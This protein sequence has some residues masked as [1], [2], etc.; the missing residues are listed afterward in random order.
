MFPNLRAEMARKHI[1]LISLAE[2]TGIN[3]ETLKGRMAGDTEFRRTEMVAIKNI[4][5]EFTMD[6][7]FSK[8]AIIKEA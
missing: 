1:T 5:P 7:L 2:K 3:I 6:Y 4:F 8:E